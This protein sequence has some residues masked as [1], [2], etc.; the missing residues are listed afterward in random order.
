MFEIVGDDHG[1]A[2][3]HVAGTHQHRE[4]DFAGDAR[5]FFGNERRAVARLRDFQFVEQAAEPAAVFREVDRFRARC[6]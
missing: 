1:A 4:A 6:R 3:E 2:A 5:G